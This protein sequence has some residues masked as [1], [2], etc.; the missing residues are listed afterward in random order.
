MKGYRYFALAA[1]TALAP[2]LWAAE[3]DFP[4]P[5]ELEPDVRFWVRVYTEI[6]T[7]GGFLHD[8]RDLSIV[9]ETLRFPAGASPRTRS[10]TVTDAKDRYTAILKKLA[11]GERD[12][13]SAEE[14]RVLELWPDGIGKARFAE[15]VSDLRFQ[16]GQSNRFREGLVRS[17]AWVPHIRASFEA[18]GLPPELAAL[19]HVESSFNTA[20]WSKVGA[21]GM[22]QFMRSTGRRYMR[23]DHVVDERMDPFASTLA[24]AQ[25]LKH[26]YEVTGTWPL[27]LIAYNHGAAGMRRA[28]RLHGT[29]DVLTIVRQYRGRTFGFASRNFYLA[30]LAALEVDRNPDKY[31]GPMRRARAVDY[32]VVELTDYVS[33][34]TLER[35]FGVDRS[36]LMQSNP[37]LMASVWSGSKHV[38]RGFKLRLPRHALARPAAEM[39][40]AISPAERFAAQTPDLFHTIVRGDT[41]S[42]IAARY[43]AAI[44]ELVDLNGLRSRHSIRAGQ[45]LRLPGAGA[46][47]APALAFTALVPPADGIYV[48]RRGDSL[49][50]IARRFDLSES[51]LLALNGLTDRNRIAAGEKLRLAVPP[52]EAAAV[53]TAQAVV[54]AGAEPPV[55]VVAI[56]AEEPELSES[57]VAEVESAEPTS[58]EEA[59]EF[60]SQV[61]AGAHPALTADPGDY[62]VAGDETIEVQAAETLG[63]YAEWL[64]LR[65]SQLRRINAMSFTRPVVIGRRLKLDFSKVTAAEFERRRVDYQRALQE[66]FF[67][68]HQ[69]R[70]TRTH[71]V[72]RGESLWVLAQRKYGVPVW[73]LRQYNP[74]VDLD[75]VHPGTTL[76]IPELVETQREPAA[77]VEQSTPQR[78]DGRAARSATLS[79]LD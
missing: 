5:P 51:E 73:L 54:E 7:N 48:V 9:Y 8:A 58:D 44:Q 34:A 15:G 22:W 77:A 27:A 25:L 6:D 70:D 66:A 71:I 57:L 3:G 75:N 12:G 62:T 4:R 10:R 20:A 26:N 65:A 32:E 2:P 24:A 46:G 11:R 43:G 53:A 18:M 52:D 28:I 35:A 76:V 55:E 64:E 59:S 79:A 74:D 13:L 31:F 38:P 23:I 39:L 49:S 19:P 1:L 72:R 67:V 14:K 47:A 69:I 33:A 41:L 17:G 30:F 45:V 63:H 68:N 50:A 42:T 37:S 36:T 78:P 60:G 61:L 29:T 40:A 21:A 56:A 16:L